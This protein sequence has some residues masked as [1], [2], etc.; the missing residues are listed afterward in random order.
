M[1]NAHHDDSALMQHADDGLIEGARGA[2]GTTEHR[3]N[4]DDQLST[5][6]AVVGA[7][8]QAVP[9][10]LARMLNQLDDHYVAYDRDWRYVF[11]ND[12]AAEV[13]GLPK[14]QLLGRCIWELFPDAVGNAYYQAVH[15]A[16]DEQRNLAVEFYYPPFARWFEN[17]IY[18][19]PTGVAVLGTDIT[20]RKQ[21]EAVAQSHARQATFR[22]ALTDTL[23]PLADPVAIQAEAARV[24]G[25][26][27]G[28]SRVAYFEVL[29]TNYVVERDY[30]AGTHPIAGRFP[31]SSFGTRLLGAYRAG[32]TAIAP[33][34]Q[35]DPDLAPAERAAFAAIQIRAFVGVPL[36]KNDQFVAGL[37]VHMAVPRAWTD[38]EVALIEE[39][40]ERTWAAVERARAEA[41]LRASEAHYRTLLDSIDQGFCVFEMLYDA[42][43]T[44]SDYRFLTVT[45]AFERHTG[46]KDA[47][48]KTARELVPNLEQHWVEMYGRV[49]ET[50]EPLRFEQESAVMGRSLEVEAVRVGEAGSRRVALMFTDVTERRRA[51]EAV[52][53]SDER[54]RAFIANSTEGVYR[55]EFEPPI[56]TALPTE[57]QI[58]LLYQR[59]RLAECNDAFAH[60]YGF[61]H[62]GELVGQSLHLMLPPDDPDARAYLAGIIAANY[63]VGEV[64]SV[65]HD[66]N[67]QLVHLANSVIG[68]VEAGKLVRAWGVQRDVTDRKRAEAQLRESEAR[69]RMLAAT[70]PQLIWTAT[71]DGGVDYLNAQWADYIGLPAERL[72]DWSWQQVVHPEDLPHT[73]RMWRDS[74]R[75]G[76]ALEIKHRFR[77]HTGQ[78]RWQLVRGQPITDDTGRITKWVG[79][80]TDVHDAEQAAAD[81]RLLSEVAEDIRVAEEAEQLLDTVVKRVGQAFQVT[82][83]YI[84]EI[85][86][87]RDRW[88]VQHEFCRVPPSL[89]GQYRISDYPLVAVQAMRSG[90]VLLAQDTKTDLRSASTYEAAYAP[91]GVRAHIIVP[92]LHDGQWVSNLVVATDTP[93]A[94]QEREVR[95]LEVVAER[96]W[97]AVEKVRLNASL[98][99]RE[100]ALALALQAGQAGTFEWNIRD[101]V[102]IWSP[103]MEALYGLPVGSFEGTYAAWA[104]RVVPEDVAVVASGIQAALAAHQHEHTYEFRAVLPDGR[105]RWLTGRARFDYNADG[106]PLRMRGINVDIHERK[107]A[108]LHTQ[109]LLD[110]DAQLNQRDDPSTIEQTM[111]ERLGVYLD[112]GGCYLGHIDGEQVAIRHEWRRGGP[113]ALATYQLADYLSPEAIAQFRASVPMI[114]ADVT[115][116]ARTAPGA[117]G[118][119]ALGI[120]ALVTTPVVHQGRW[121]GTLN[122]VSSQ[123]R[124]WRADEIQLLR[125]IVARV[126]P[127][128]EQARALQALRVSEERLQV[129]YAEEQAARAQAEEASRLK[130]EFLATVSH[131]LRTPLTAILGYAHLLRSRKRDEAYVA[132]TVQ[133]IVDSAQAQVQLTEDI[134]DV[135]RVVSGKLRL[136][137]QPTEL[138]SVI[139]A[140]VDA[141]RPALDAKA[142][143]L[144]VALEPMTAPILGDASRLQQVVWNLLSNAVKFTP[145]QGSV[146]VRWQRLG[147]TGRL[148]VSDT[149]QGID[150]AFL[151]Y[152]WERFRQAD[153][154]STRA[155]GGLGLGLSIVRHLVELHGGTVRAY[156]TGLGHGATFVVELPLIGQGQANAPLDATFAPSADGHICPPELAGLRVLVVDDQPALVALLHEVLAPCVA[157]VR[158]CSNATDALATLRAWRPDLLISDIAMPHQ[159][160]YWL[161]DAVRALPAEEGGTIPAIALTAYVRV[162]E[163]ARVLATG[164][165]RYVPKPVEPNELLAGI[166][167]LLEATHS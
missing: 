157:E 67:G 110:L 132:R 104:S 26:Q 41:T 139:D 145:P 2:S 55:L 46:L 40:A 19:S 39:T 16:L 156:S 82:R 142:T 122:I 125:D 96:V 124:A 107:Q 112:L 95:L 85:D 57:A 83:C 150:P 158:T 78:W 115:T 97:L 79:T 151:P 14:D 71:P 161:I 91:I 38:D 166:V 56:N 58:D 131:E 65:E 9:V 29:G 98:H 69:F 141:V 42:N 92:M 28:A 133:K 80:C 101:D 119:L 149:G 159:D 154:S 113:S 152:V 70:L 123:P 76:A 68:V 53:A 120:R 33:D 10:D 111:L 3:A 12:A 155:H 163:R 138:S 117:A 20:A 6:S 93:R 130:D 63:R 23:R 51:E 77:H 22:A 109:F 167:D 47:V 140:A 34:V 147:A 52:R 73:L 48:G 15:Q 165:Q 143:H 37:A 45:P 31:I 1:S 103:E 66:R 144:T 86:E 100:A 11:V 36:V 128:L 13:L 7:E 18:A 126:W 129:L 102:N 162:E 64:E 59:G 135:A 114:V 116:D 4:N 50:G 148:T 60:T 5:S 84:A 72:Y 118:F 87:P 88:F 136:E 90:Q 43:G 153:S 17:R 21:A 49:A 105:Q 121:V 74:I 8:T 27:L 32:R 61:T 75:S 54:Y 106:S 134:L 146:T 24:L 89:Q 62:A 160:G 127:L 44:H 35:A 81:A 108:E 137:M 94:W 99:A 30:T 164:F 25:Q